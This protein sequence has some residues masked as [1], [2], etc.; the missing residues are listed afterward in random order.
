MPAFPAPPADKKELMVEEGAV[1]FFLLQ[2]QETRFEPCGASPGFP[3]KLPVIIRSQVDGLNP[4]SLKSLSNAIAENCISLPIT[5]LSGTA[6][7]GCLVGAWYY[8]EVRAYDM[9]LSNSFSGSQWTC[10]EITGASS[11]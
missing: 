3:A 4:L 7:K 2:G 1:M 10:L 11:S 9:I 6:A 8:K 5:L